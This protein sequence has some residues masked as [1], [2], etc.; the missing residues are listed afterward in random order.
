MTGSTQEN[1]DD[2]VIHSPSGP[3]L[4]KPEFERDTVAVVLLVHH[5][6]DFS[7]ETTS[8]FT[9]STESS[10]SDQFDVICERMGVEER[11]CQHYALQIGD[12]S[13]GM[14]WYPYEEDSDREMARHVRRAKEERE[15]QNLSSTDRQGE[16]V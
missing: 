14:Y 9:L 3:A 13:S 4:Q 12:K 6:K 5:E 7:R 15:R 8:Q 11:K 16:K 10:T 2:T 1:M